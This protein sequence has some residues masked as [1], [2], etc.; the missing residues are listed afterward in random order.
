MAFDPGAFVTMMVTFYPVVTIAN[1]R[2][3]REERPDYFGGGHLFGTCGEKLRLPTARIWDLMRDCGGRN[4]AWQAIDVTDGG[5]GGDDPFV[6]DRGPLDELELPPIVTEGGETVFTN[7]VAAALV[8]LGGSDDVLDHAGDLIVE[9]GATSGL[10]DALQADLSE[11]VGARQGERQALDALNVSEL[12]DATN[13][14]A[15]VAE[16][17][18]GTPDLG[19]DDPPAEED[20]RDPGPRPRDDDDRDRN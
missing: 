18:P 7:L 20:P 8:E 15:D 17:E 14:N 12:L 1:L 11:A 16:G 13:D 19:D 10:S 9:G 5:G 2:R 6:L 4:A 3:A